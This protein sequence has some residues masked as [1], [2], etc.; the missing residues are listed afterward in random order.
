MAG[1]FCSYDSAISLQCTRWNTRNVYLYLLD[2]LEETILK[3]LEEGDY[4][5]ILAFKYVHYF[6][7]LSILP[8]TFQGLESIGGCTISYPLFQG[9]PYQEPVL[10]RAPSRLRCN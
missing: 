3:V 9:M 8:E 4:R 1:T 2:L 5:A 7:L 6:Y 10:L